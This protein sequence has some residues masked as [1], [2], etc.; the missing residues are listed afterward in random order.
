MPDVLEDRWDHCKDW[1]RHR[2]APED[3]AAW[4]APLRLNDVEPHRI[5][6]GGIPNSFFKNRIAV[7]YRPLILEGLRSQFPDIPFET[8]PVFELQVDPVQDGDPAPL[9]GDPAETGNAPSRAGTPAAGATAADSASSG[10][11]ERYRFSSFLQDDGTRDALRLAKS[12]LT[13]PATRFNPFML[14]GETG[15]GKT[16][17]AQAMGNAL[18]SAPSSAKVIYHTGEEFKN[19]VLEGITRRRMPRVRAHYRSAEVL[20]VDDLQFLLVSPAAQEE[21]L[22]TID[23][24]HR[25]GAQMI[26]TAARYPRDLPRL[27]EALAARIE[28]GLVAEVAMPGQAVRRQLAQIHAERAGCDLPLEV[29]DLLARRITRSLRQLEGA[30]IRLSAYGALHQVAVTVDFADKIAAPYFD[31]QPGEGGGIPLSPEVIVE[32][33]ADRFG[34]TIRALKGRSRAA[35]LGSARRVAIHLLKTHARCSYP[36]IGSLLGNRAHSTVLHSHQLLLGEMKNDDRLTQQVMK[37]T[38]DLLPP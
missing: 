29:A 9:A 38:R 2:V 12:I 1:I 5:V 31:S 37:L 17:L 36:Q 18:A 26:F 20:I 28:M 35:N 34:V 13:A 24:L 25:K 27:N 33:V 30:V 15:T 8:E 7:R 10:L 23:H 22:H 19:D 14:V 4:L 16:H 3:A 11:M 32:R 21:L 6:L